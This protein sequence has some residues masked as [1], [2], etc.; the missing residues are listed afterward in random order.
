MAESYDFLG[1]INTKKLWWSFKVYIIRIWE[2]PSKFNEK[3][4]QSIEM[5]LQDSKGNRMIASIPKALVQKWSGLIIQFQ[6]YAMNNFIVV[7]NTRIAQTIPSQWILTF[8]HRTTVNQIQEPSF[9]LEA[10][11]FRTIVELL[12]ADKILQSDLFDVIAEVVGKEDPRDLVTTKGKETKRMVI[13]LEDLE[14]NKID[15]ILFGK[16]VDQILPHLE[17]GTV[18]PVIV[19]LQFFKAIRWNGKTSLH[20]HF[21][22]SKIHINSQLKEIETF[23][24]RL[25]S[26]APATT[27]VRISQ[28]SSQSKWSTVDELTQGPTWI[29]GTIVAIN[30]GKKDWYYKSCRNCPKK[31]DTPIGNRYE[32][33]KCGHTHGSAALRF[34]VEVMVYDGTGSISLL[35]WDREMVQ[36]CGKRAEQIRDTEAEGD[37]EYP[38]TLNNIMDR[39]LL[40]KINVKSA[41]IKQFDQIY[42]VM[43]ICDD[44][45]IIEKN[46]QSVLSAEPST[47]TEGGCSNSV[48]VSADFNLKNDCDPEYNLDAMEES[49]SSLKCKTPL[50]RTSNIL[51]C[52][53]QFVN[54]TDE[55]GQ[56]S[57]NK[58]SRK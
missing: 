5:I 3:E 45:E 26:D 4:V 10:F 48:H 44:E 38:P 20:S 31:V 29:T 30:A 24:N 23:K 54:E 41:N 56:L 50:K 19:L 47:N 22:V 15:C 32:C 13:V 25:L 27:S 12:N 39:K 43:K 1:D 16:M 35:L 11:R 21:E 36:L 14:H 40:L 18:E 28:I 37:D 53:S 2:L 6:M 7:K 57:T 42:T 51:K 52:G 46:T 33:D 8:S 49:I 58:F 55:D 9:P 17:D 34:K